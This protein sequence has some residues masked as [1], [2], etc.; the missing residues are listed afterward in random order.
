MNATQYTILVKSYQFGEV[1]KVRTPFM[2]ANSARLRRRCDKGSY[3]YVVTAPFVATFE[4]RTSVNGVLVGRQRVVVHVPTDFLADGNSSR[5]F[6]T[7]LAWVFHDWLY[8]THALSHR[9]LADDAMKQ[10]LASEGN[11]VEWWATSAVMKLF[12]WKFDNAWNSSG[13]R[14]PEFFVGYCNHQ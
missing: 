3:Q 4:V 1:T 2:V 7:S 9:H 5:F 13:E 8:A 10:I 12:G 6:N 14:G 11:T